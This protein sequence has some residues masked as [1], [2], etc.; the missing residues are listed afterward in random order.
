[1]RLLVSGRRSSLYKEGDEVY[2]HFH[3]T[4]TFA[5]VPV[6]LDDKGVRRFQQNGTERSLCPRRAPS[7]G[8][9]RLRTW[10]R[11][12]RVIES[13]RASTSRLR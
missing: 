8:R 1:M 12:Q 2:R 5:P 7:R 13:H 10:K 4:G 9:G 3:D 11:R 6:R